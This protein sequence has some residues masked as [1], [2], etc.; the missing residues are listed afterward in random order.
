MRTLVAIAL[1]IIVGA[2]ATPAF[3]DTPFAVGQVWTLKG[4]DYPTA[5]VLIDRLEMFG[6]KPIAHITVLHVPVTDDAGAAMGETVVG[7]MPFTEEALGRSVGALVRSDSPVYDQFEAGYADWKAANGGVFTITV[8]EGI[9]IVL[10]AMHNAPPPK[11]N[12]TASATR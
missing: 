2:L 3:A 10:E 1:M 12:E 11:P 8:P 9:A 7:H 6:G 5:Q 4:S